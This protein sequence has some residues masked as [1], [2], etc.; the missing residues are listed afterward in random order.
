MR[1]TIKKD[2]FA[3]SSKRLGATRRA[4]MLLLVMMLTMAQTATAAITGSGT[5]DDPYLISSTEDWN[6]FANNVNNG[7][8]Y[9][10]KT[11]KLNADI[12]VTTMVGTYDYPFNGTFDGGGHTLN[13]TLNSGNQYGYDD[14]YYGVAPF[15]FTNGATIQFLAVTGIVTTSTLKYAAG[16]IGMTKGGTNTIM[17]CISS[18]EIFSTIAL[19]DFDGT[20]GGFIGKAS[21]TVTINNSLFNGQ[22]TT[23]SDNPTINCGGFVGWRD[24]TL[25]ISNCLYAPNT[26]I[27]SGKVAIDEGAT[28]SRNDVTPTNSYYT[29]TLGAAQG[30][31]VGSKTAAQLVA[32]LG[33]AWRVSSEILYHSQCEQSGQR[34]NHHPIR[35][36]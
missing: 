34:R 3:P 2:I 4:A 9:S 17:N 19:Y 24:G 28:F 11:V 21:G 20:H 7:T 36:Q 35:R 27:P 30:T 16:L 31:A 14:A 25:S 26:T 15:R 6:T 1:K 8:S 18:V 12:S 5:A 29:Q 33:S 32:A 22:L 10:G 23:T 13:V